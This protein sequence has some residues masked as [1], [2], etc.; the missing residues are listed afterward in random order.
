MSSQELEKYKKEFAAADLKMLQAEEDLDK[1]NEFMEN[2]EAMME[3]LH[4]LAEFYFKGNW[5]EKREM[6]EEAGMA[7]YGSASED[8]IWNLVVEFQGEKIR[9]LKLLTD[10]IYRDTFDK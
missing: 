7:N 9:L 10:D 8:G 3:N 1:L 6:L 2:Y 4:Q 5:V